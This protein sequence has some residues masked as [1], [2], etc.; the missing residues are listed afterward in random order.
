M[1][2]ASFFIVLILHQFTVFLGDRAPGFLQPFLAGSWVDPR[3]GQ[4]SAFL[5]VSSL[6]DSAIVGMFA[7]LLFGLIH[8]AWHS[9]MISAFTKSAK[10]GIALVAASA[11]V[12]III[13]IVV[14]VTNFGTGFFFLIIRRFVLFTG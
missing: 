1:A 10:N 5:M 6:L 8:P 12:G 14:L 7:L 9:E 2:F 3:T 4:V 13:G 11:C